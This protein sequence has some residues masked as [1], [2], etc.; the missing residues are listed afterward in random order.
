MAHSTMTTI[1]PRTIQP[2]VDMGLLLET[3]GRAAGGECL[4]HTRRLRLDHYV[5]VFDRHRKRL[6]LVGPLD[7]LGAGLDRYRVLARTQAL[8]V[9]PGAAGSDVEL[10]RMPGAADDLAPPRI[11]VRAR[12]RGFEQPGKAAMGEASPLVGTA[13]VKSEE[14]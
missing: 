14:L 6:G 13:I 12:L 11:A 7:Q 5:V 2:V 3:G 8:R 1:T 4:A 9:A 10:P